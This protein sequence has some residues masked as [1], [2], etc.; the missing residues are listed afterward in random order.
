[1]DRNSPEHYTASC[2]ENLADTEAFIKA[3]QYVLVASTVFPV[4]DWIERSS[5]AAPDLGAGHG[6]VTCSNL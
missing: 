5:E 3:I 6:E 4:I 2:E 1:M